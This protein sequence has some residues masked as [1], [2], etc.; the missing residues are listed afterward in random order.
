MVSEGV[1]VNMVVVPGGMSVGLGVGK[2]DVAAASVGTL[3]A[4]EVIPCEAFASVTIDSE[5]V[6]PAI[7]CATTTVAST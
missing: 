5:A 3:V 4:V 2:R 6:G 7:T 1:A